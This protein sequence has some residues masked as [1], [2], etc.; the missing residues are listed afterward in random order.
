MHLDGEAAIDL[1]LIT[2]NLSFDRDI[3][4]KNFEKAKRALVE[5]Y[6]RRSPLGLVEQG[7][8]VATG[9]WT[10]PIVILAAE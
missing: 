9:M 1:Q 4:V 6:K 5:T 8:N 10:A 7:I 2:S 3:Y